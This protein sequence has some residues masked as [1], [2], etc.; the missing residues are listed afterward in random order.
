MSQNS[1]Y[2]V[3]KVKSTVL[4]FEP[5][6]NKDFKVINI[7][8][9]EKISHVFF[10]KKRKMINKAFKELFKNSID[11]AKKMEIDLRLR[12]NQ[13]SEKEYYKITQ[14]YEKINF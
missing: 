8:N 6:I 10:S 2:P 12:P 4:V 3:P 14:C 11:I 5:I 7:S 13:L 1:F 9:L